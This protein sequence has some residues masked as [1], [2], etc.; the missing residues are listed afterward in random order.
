M[1]TYTIVSDQ[2]GPF[3]PHF[4]VVVLGGR[5]DRILEEKFATQEDAH[6]A[7]DRLRR[8]EWDAASEDGG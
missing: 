1:N 8:E 6:I 4:R 2:E 7:V 3:G 5:F